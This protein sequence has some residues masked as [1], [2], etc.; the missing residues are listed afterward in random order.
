MA[1]LR[2]PACSGGGT[3]RVGRGKCPS[4]WLGGRC[5]TLSGSV[6]LTCLSVAPGQFR[7]VVHRLRR[8]TEGEA[9]LCPLTVLPPQ[10]PCDRSSEVEELRSIIE[11][12][13][14][15]QQR[16]QREK[17]EETERLHEVIE[18]L[19]RELSLG[20]TAGSGVESGQALAVPAVGPEAL[21]AAGATGQL[22]AEQERRHGQALEALQQR[23]RAAEE[24]AATRLADLERCAAHGEAEVRG[25]AAQ[26]QAFEA[27]LEAKEAGI[28]E[29]D[30]EIDAMKQ[31]KLAQ[32]A[33]LEALLAAFSHFRLALEQQP[34]AAETEGEPPELRRLRVQ[35]VRLGRQLQ[36]LHLR[37]LSC[38]GQPDGQQ[39]PRV[40]LH[41]HVEGCPQGQSPRAAGASWDEE[42]QPPTAPQ[43]RAGDAQVSCAP[44]C[45]CA[46]GLLSVGRGAGDAGVRGAHGCRGVRG[47]RGHVGVGTGVG[48]GSTGTHA[49][50]A[51][52]WRL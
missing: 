46:G 29:R 42:S 3:V 24:A 35:C 20:G 41:P 34:L 25:L 7:G 1:G 14:E 2:P 16:L 50:P 17:A 43:G 36:L 39:A 44:S 19:Q 8:G 32:S 45:R 6:H 23:L 51:G 30:S 28:A 49:E 26:I 27:A 37:F 40:H 33:E 47:V 5:V 9:W 52:P 38:Q 22:L 4:R 10:V 18:R 21:A 12:L 13:R 48:A 11:N 31:Q 15:N